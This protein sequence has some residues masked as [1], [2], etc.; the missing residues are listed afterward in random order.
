MA[1]LLDL[2]VRRIVA[3]R[4]SECCSFFMLDALEARA[5]AG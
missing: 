3:R 4:E 1:V 2:V 5:S